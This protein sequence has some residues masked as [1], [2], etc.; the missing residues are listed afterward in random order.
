MT[1]D[2]IAKTEARRRLLRLSQQ[3]L[4]QQ[5]DMTQGHYSKLVRRLV[6]L[7]PSAEG[8]LKD[9]LEQ[10]HNGA[11]RKG[12]ETERLAGLIALH[13]NGLSD[14]VKAFLKELGNQSQVE[15]RPTKT[16]VPRP[17]PS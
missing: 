12:D 5:L 17:R 6:P 16:L 13:A 4:A 3:D 8:K 11:H 14:A 2:L 7:A 1:S 9:W 10:S 15:A